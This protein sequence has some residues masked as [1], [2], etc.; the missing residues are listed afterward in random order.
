M[1]VF[2]SAIL[3]LNG[4]YILIVGCIVTSFPVGPWTL[5]L[6]FNT[7]EFPLVPTATLSKVAC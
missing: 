3:K 2:I 6:Y 1:H 4:G 5:A 7:A